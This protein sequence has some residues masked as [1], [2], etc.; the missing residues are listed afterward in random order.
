MK[1]LPL[2]RGYFNF[3]FVNK[4][5]LLNNPRSYVLLTR[6]FIVSLRVISILPCMLF[7]LKALCFDIINLWSFEKRWRGNFCL[8]LDF[9][10]T[11]SKGYFK[12]ILTKKDCLPNNPEIWNK[13]CIAFWL[14]IGRW[15]HVLFNMEDN[16]CLIGIV[17]KWTSWGGANHFSLVIVPSDLEFLYQ[18]RRPVNFS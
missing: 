5:G 2:D 1:W 3:I 17:F 18:Y 7:P 13:L 11:S 4:D 9:L 8:I 16:M 15:K 14:K 10:A 6:N 12:F